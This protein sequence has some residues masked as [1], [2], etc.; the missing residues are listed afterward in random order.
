LFFKTNNKSA[1]GEDVQQA[2]IVSARC[3]YGLPDDAVVYCNFNQLYKIDPPTLEMWMNILKAVPD[4]VLW[5][6]R[7][8]AVGEP[9]V[10]QCA[11]NSG[12]AQARII[13]SPVA[14]KVN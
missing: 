10:L 7:F 11:V 9:N 5:L 12:V 4:S 14:P 1:T 8:P 6:L 3:Q 13:F 2:I